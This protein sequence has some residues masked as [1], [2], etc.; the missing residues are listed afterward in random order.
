MSRY[1]VRRWG[2]EIDRAERQ[3]NVCK[4]MVTVG[5]AAD[6]DTHSEPHLTNEVLCG[7]TVR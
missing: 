7:M 6:R 5:V 4:H 3:R 1:L 2:V